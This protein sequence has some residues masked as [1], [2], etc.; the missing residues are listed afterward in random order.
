MT[1]HHVEAGHAPALATLTD[2]RLGYVRHAA[3]P[4]RPPDSKNSQP[5]PPW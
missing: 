4:G 5:D 3:D 1:A 2:Q